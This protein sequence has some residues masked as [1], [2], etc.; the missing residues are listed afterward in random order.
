MSRIWAFAFGPV[1]AEVWRWMNISSVCDVSSFRSGT[2]RL[3]L[4][5]R[6]E[7]GEWRCVAAQGW[8]NVIDTQGSE[9]IKDA[10][11]GGERAKAWGGGG[12]SEICEQRQRVD[13]SG[14]AARSL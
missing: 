3:T 10:K 14:Y 5:P 7:R 11:S 1:A 13:P 2:V 4:L 9:K 8:R 6:V 12:Q